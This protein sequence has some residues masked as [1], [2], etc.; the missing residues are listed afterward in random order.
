MLQDAQSST[1]P[2][3]FILIQIGSILHLQLH[4]SSLD[5]QILLSIL[6]VQ[7]AYPIV[8]GPKP[9]RLVNIHS[10]SLLCVRFPKLFPN[11]EGSESRFEQSSLATQVFGTTQTKLGCEI[12]LSVVEEMAVWVIAEVESVGRRPFRF[13][14]VRIVGKGTQRWCVVWQC[15]E[16][17]II[18][19]HGRAMAVWGGRTTFG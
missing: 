4:P 19:F 15:I 17:D 7:P 8:S 12:D 2:I 11:L 6:L 10:T 5:R 16:I 18:T 13:E 14:D 1:I 9:T 3:A